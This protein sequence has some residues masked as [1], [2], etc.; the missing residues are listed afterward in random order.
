MDVL[1]IHTYIY[2]V[3]YPVPGTAAATDKQKFGT[4]ARTP[5]PLANHHP[6]ALGMGSYFTVQPRSG[7]PLSNGSG[8]WSLSSPAPSQTDFSHTH[9]FRIFGSLG[10]LFSVDEGELPTGWLD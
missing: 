7:L 9:N 4:E 6:M 5:G 1:Y 8:C 3:L 2:A 10:T